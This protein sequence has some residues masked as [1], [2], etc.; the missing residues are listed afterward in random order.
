MQI[1]FFSASVVRYTTLGNQ[2]CTSNKYG[3]YE[4]LDEAKQAC[5]GDERCFGVFQPKCGPIYE[6][7]YSLCPKQ[8]GYSGNSCIHEKHAALPSKYLLLQ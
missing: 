8:E 4:N 1:C 2:H 6:S 5:T 7:K 3:Q